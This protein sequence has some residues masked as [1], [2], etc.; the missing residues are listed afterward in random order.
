MYFVE[1]GKVKTYKTNEDG[2]EFV[3]GLYSAGDFFGYMPF[4]EGANY[5]DT[6]E[7]LEE[8]ELAVIPK[9]DFEQ[10][11]NNNKEVM[12]QFIKLLANNVSEMEQ[13]LL[14][15]AYNSLRKKVADAL[16][17][18]YKKYGEGVPNFRIDMSRENLANIAG[19]AKES[20]IRTLS[21]FKDEKLIDI[22]K[23]DIIILDEKKLS[24]MMN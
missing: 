16:I 2:K 9:E 1:S 13:Q 10:L 23:G 6:A 15:L 4:L 22:S 14:N 21:D 19:T 7:A 11:L 8:T 5:K 20:V 12:Y 24:N 3:I 17:T 18:I